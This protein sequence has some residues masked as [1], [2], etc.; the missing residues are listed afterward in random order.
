MDRENFASQSS[1]ILEPG[2]EV[3][4]KLR[5]D[6]APE[7]WCN[8]RL[9]SGSGRGDLY[10]ARAHYGAEKKVAVGDVIDAIGEDATLDGEPVNLGVYR[11][12]I[13]CSDDDKVAIK[14]GRFKASLNPFQLAYSC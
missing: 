4:G 8:S 10:L 12:R 11:G 3:S 5:V 1:E 9:F 13:S 6:F 2:A 14:I 7:A